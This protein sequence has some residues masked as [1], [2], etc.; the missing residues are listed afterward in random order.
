MVE[1]DDMIKNDLIR[2]CPKCGSVNL[3]QTPKPWEQKSGDVIRCECM[4]CGYKGMDFPSI[5]KTTVQ[6]FRQKIKKK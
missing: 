1:I 5:K 3:K 6:L 4:L 2:I